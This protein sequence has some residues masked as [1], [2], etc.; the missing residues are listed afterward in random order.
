MEVISSGAV[1]KMDE[2]NQVVYGWASLIEKDDQPIIDN[3]GDIIREPVLI[4]AAHGFISDAR[5]GGFMHM[6]GVQVG[7]VVESMVMTRDLQ[8]ALGIDLK[9]VGWLIGMK[10]TNEKVWKAVKAGDF[11]EFSIGGEGVRVE[12]ELS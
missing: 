1:L 2:E 11:P 9:K 8:K 3:Q 6:D 7:T 5:K 10:V 4:K 12:A